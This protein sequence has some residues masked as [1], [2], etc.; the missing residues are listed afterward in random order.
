MMHSPVWKLTI[1]LTSTSMMLTSLAS[2]TP[3]QFSLFDPNYKACD[4]SE[5]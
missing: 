2:D 1:T 4:V 5:A 3:L